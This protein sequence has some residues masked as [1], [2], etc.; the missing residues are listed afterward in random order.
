MK[1]DEEEM[2]AV[3]AMTNQKG[4]RVFVDYLA[5]MQDRK[6][7]QMK[8]CRK[9]DTVKDKLQYLSCIDDVLQFFRMC[10]TQVAEHTQ[11]N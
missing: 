3:L 2:S 7:T 9:E 5:E 8:K 11:A 6:I 10:R 1:L 4:F